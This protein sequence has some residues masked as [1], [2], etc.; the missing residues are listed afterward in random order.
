M[1]RIVEVVNE[2]KILQNKRDYIVVNTNGK[3]ENHG[4]FKKLSTCYV[5]IRLL[6]RKTIPKSD[7]LL[8]AA[9]RITTDSQYKQ[10]LELKQEKN[11]QRQRYFN[12]NK[13]VRR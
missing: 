4:H 3:Y 9:R 10:T 2:Y 13:G 5:I 1:S 12:S 7:Y 6:Q 8:E 11:K